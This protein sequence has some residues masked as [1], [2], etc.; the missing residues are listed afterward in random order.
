MSLT[1]VQSVSSSA[2]SSKAELHDEVGED[3]GERELKLLHQPWLIEGEPDGGEV[4]EGYQGS[5]VQGDIPE[6]GRLDL[7]LQKYFLRP[8]TSL[9]W[10]L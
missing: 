6:A 9:L 10:G 1:C 3:D 8:R 4:V 5:S 7:C 2:A